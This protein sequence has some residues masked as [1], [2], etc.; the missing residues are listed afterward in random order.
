MSKS[1]GVAPKAEK[2]IRI[3]KSGDLRAVQRVLW[4]SIVTTRDMLL[5]PEIDD[6]TR[7]KAATAIGQ[8]IG[9]YLKV[10]EMSEAPAVGELQDEI[11]SL[12]QMGIAV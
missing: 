6:L 7:L 3:R 12:K 2:L 4:Q 10:L 9:Q 8:N 5:R 11:D 1:N